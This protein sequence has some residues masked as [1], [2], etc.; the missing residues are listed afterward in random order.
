MSA[1]LVV[2]LGPGVVRFH[3]S[4][5]AIATAA[6]GGLAV[7]SG[8]AISSLSGV[9]I[10]E[11][12]DLL[13]ADTHC[14][15]WA[16]GQAFGS[17]PLLIGV[18]TSDTTTSGDFTDPMSGL[19]ADSNIPAPW[20]SGGFIIVGSGPGT[21]L[22]IFGSGVSGSIV[23]SGWAAAAGF[24]RPHRYVR[25]IALSGFLLDGGFTAGFM[26]QLKSTGP[27]GFAGYSY[28]PSSGTPNV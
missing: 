4:F 16:A 18:Q 28:L 22:G 13:D 7:T 2:D 10:G 27:S 1:N 24:Q 17:G 23:L 6:D 15:L 5:P 14:N 8:G 9:M 12:V 26:G 20:V 21:N 11:V 3:R 25:A 19:A